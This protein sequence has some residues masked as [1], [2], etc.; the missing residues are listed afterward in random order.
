MPKKKSTI[1]ELKTEID[2]INEIVQSEN[3]KILPPEEPKEEV[4]E[5]PVVEKKEEPIVNF[6]PDKFAE[7]TAQKVKELQDKAEEAKLQSQKQEQLK[8][9]ENDETIPAYVKEGRNPR[10]YAEINDE[11]QRI[12]EIKFNR[13]LAER[14]LQSVAK[15]EQEAKVR[16][17]Q[18]AKSKQFEEDFNKM[19]DEEMDEL[20]KNDRLPKIADKDDP[21]DVGIKAKFELFKTMKETNEKRVKE[22]L[23][24]ITSVSRIFNNYYKAPTGPAGADAPINAGSRSVQTPKDE[25]GYTYA[26]IKKKSF[27]DWFKVK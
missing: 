10:D 11:A 23:Q 2:E 9:K 20:Y 5:T 26:D 17:E 4:V 1:V 15:S 8:A 16:E 14:E 13:I 12:A 3:D 25:L 18:L 24:P 21:N 6:D 22:G 7:Q 27:L 19:I